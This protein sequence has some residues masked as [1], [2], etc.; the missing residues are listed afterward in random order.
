MPKI[1]E[2]DQRIILDAFLNHKPGKVP[3]L[4]LKIGNKPHSLKEI[5]M[6]QKTSLSF[7]YWNYNG[8]CFLKSSTDSPGI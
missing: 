8:I 7:Q 5:T 2:P 3:L 4:T 6:Q 1:E